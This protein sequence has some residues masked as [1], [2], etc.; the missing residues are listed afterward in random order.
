MKLYS[1]N[2]TLS[3][4]SFKDAVFNSM[5]QDKGLYMPISIPRLS[6]DFIGN[7]DKYTLPEIAFEVAKTLLGDAMPADDLKALIDDAINFD[8]PVV[9]LDDNVHVLEL[10]HGPSLAFKDFGARFMSRV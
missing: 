3:E 5:P 2:N 10:F 6:D 7:L 4:V 9:K 1:T 8:A